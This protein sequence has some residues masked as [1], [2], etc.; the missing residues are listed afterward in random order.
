MYIVIPLKNPE[1]V[2]SMVLSV[3]SVSEVIQQWGGQVDKLLSDEDLEKSGRFLQQADRDRFIAARIL[4]YELLKDQFEIQLPLEFDYS[5]FGKPKLRRVPE[6]SWSH[7]GGF[8][9][10]F[11]A[12]DAGI[13][14]E[15]FSEVDTQSFTS[16][17]T[18]N[19]LEW[20]GSS[21]VNFFKLW[22]IKE[23]VMKSTGLGFQLNP[24]ELNP[25]F[26]KET[27]DFWQVNFEQSV[28]YGR[29][30]IMPDKSGNSYALS[31]CT[32]DIN[33]KNV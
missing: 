14:I 15:L 5:Q 33:I 9:A 21:R 23:A 26:T 16:V 19:Q 27:K 20:I 4:C 31:F 17:F 8:V 32:S 18:R 2:K 6:F 25:I 1:I 24:L 22:S 28:F 11:C 13:D 29:T 12:P 7:S 30:F 10:L 3:R